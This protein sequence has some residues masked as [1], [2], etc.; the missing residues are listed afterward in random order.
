MECLI[1]EREREFEFIDSLKC[2]ECEQYVERFFMFSAA[3]VLTG[4][5]PA[6]LVSL[7]CGNRSAWMRHRERLE[8]ATGLR[9]MELYEKCDRFAL[10]IFDERALDVRIRSPASRTLLEAYGYSADDALE[11]LLL[12]LKSRFGACKFPHEIG[13]FLGYPPRDVGTFIEKEGRDY[14]CCR[15]WKVY[16]D[17]RGARRLF[18]FIDDSKALA[19]TLLRKQV[20]I[21]AVAQILAKAQNY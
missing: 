5:K 13:L 19:A 17:E 11:G 12:H 9:A 2:L 18:K 10:L 21:C 20:P 16:H 8:A 7:K 15:H 3:P 4:A 14:L 1:R 6:T